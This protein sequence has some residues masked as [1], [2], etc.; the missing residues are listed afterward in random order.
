VQIV[1]DAVLM[2]TYSK[3]KIRLVCPEEHKAHFAWSHCMLGISVGQN[4]HEGKG[5]FSSITKINKSFGKCSIMLADTLQ[6]HNM[7]CNYPALSWT[8]VHNLSK[9]AGDDWIAR[10]ASAISIL[11]IPHQIIRW[12]SWLNNSNYN[13]CRNL[14][15]TLYNENKD[16]KMSVFQTVQ[17]LALRLD[18]NN[19]KL[20]CLSLY[21]HSIDYIKEECAVQLLMAKAGYEF[22]LYPGK[23]NPA[24]QYTYDFLIKANPSN[25]LSWVDIKI[26]C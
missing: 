14:I 2:P 9:Q 21:K 6:R 4:K 12:D 22:I 5:L 13:A 8:E 10:N 1:S 26:N 3:V 25:V 20:N 11:T 23:P 24:M 17:E 19:S 15:D 16:F 7:K 18:K